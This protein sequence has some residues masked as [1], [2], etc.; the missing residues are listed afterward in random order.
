MSRPSINGFPKTEGTRSPAEG[1]CPDVLSADSVD[2]LV[3]DDL[4]TNQKVLRHV[5]EKCPPVR[6]RTCGSGV[7]AIRLCRERKFELVLI[8]LHMPDMTGFEAGAAILAEREGPFPLVVAQTADE[9]PRACGR[10]VEIGFDGHLVKPI[11]P[12]SIRAILDSIRRGG[13]RTSRA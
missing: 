3:V 13:L 12:E 10:T 5:V 2:V 11:R 4:P 1:A 6:V 7:E 9:T 8:D